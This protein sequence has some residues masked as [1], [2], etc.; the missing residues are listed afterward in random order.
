MKKVTFFAFA[1]ILT[2]SIS[3]NV[4]LASWWNPISWF[5][6]NATTIHTPEKTLSADGNISIK[7]GETVNVF[8]VKAKVTEITEDSRCAK[9]NECIQAG[10]VKVNVHA[11]YK[12]IFSKN[13]VLTLGV[14]YTTNGHV[15]TLTSVTPD[16][17][18]GTTINPQDYVFNFSIQSAKSENSDLAQ[19]QSFAQ[20][21]KNK[22][23]KFFGTS[24]CP[25]C[26]EQKALFNESVKD[27]PYI[28]CS[29]SDKQAT[30]APICQQNNIKGY[31]TWKFSDGTEIIKVMSLNELAEKTGCSL[32]K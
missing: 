24:W 11:V 28:E 8:G 31:P 3:P 21:L 14:P 18:A 12:L 23:A 29:T 2:L 10:T 15:V 19:N 17:I 22:G 9:G 25:H 27:L 16:K 5:Q 1:I 20:C 4:A 32:D 13:V 30:Q 6:K 7:L 26:Q